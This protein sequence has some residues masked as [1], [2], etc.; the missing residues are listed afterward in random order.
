MGEKEAGSEEFCLSLIPLHGGLGLRTYSPLL[1]SLSLIIPSKSCRKVHT[2]KI[3]AFCLSHTL[4]VS[5]SLP[6]FFPLSVY[7]YSLLACH[8]SSDSDSI[9][10][11]LP[12]CLCPTLFIS[13]CLCIPVSLSHFLSLSS[14]ALLLC[15]CSSKYC[16]HHEPRITVRLKMGVLCWCLLPVH[17]CCQA[18]VG[19]MY[20]S[21]H[22]PQSFLVSSLD[23]AKK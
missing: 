14:S 16:G 4:S 8:P 3:F 1:E 17:R 10:P 12:P 23:F 19:F 13:V 18:S 9:S 2:G 11:S 21:V 7:I 5:V 22:L 20:S 15:F 6:P